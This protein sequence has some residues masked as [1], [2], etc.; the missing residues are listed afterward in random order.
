MNRKLFQRK[1]EDFVCANCTA[2]VQ[3]DGYTNHCPECLW[4][5]HVDV[6][7]G[8]RLERCRGMMRPVATMPH[9]KGAA[10]LHRCTRCGVERKNKVHKRDSVAAVVPLSVSGKKSLLFF[11]EEI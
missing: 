8:D 6:C 7:P 2:R 10:L 5:R 3:G 11:N 9:K 1:K 4:S